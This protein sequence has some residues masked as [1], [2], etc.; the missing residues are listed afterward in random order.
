MNGR[1]SALVCTD[2]E[3]RERERPEAVKEALV[4]KVLNGV[5]ARNIPTHTQEAVISYLWSTFG[6]GNEYGQ[7]LQPP[8]DRI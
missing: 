8:T 6:S 2:Q 5:L 7:E 4:G 1:T 3:R